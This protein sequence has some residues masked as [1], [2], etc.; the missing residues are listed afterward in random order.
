MRDKTHAKD[1]QDYEKDNLE[2]VPVT[3]VSDLEQYQ[4]PSSEGVHYLEI[5]FNSAACD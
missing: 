3:V 4:F 1:S 5:R 2:E